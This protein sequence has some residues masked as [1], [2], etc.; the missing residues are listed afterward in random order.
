MLKT[1]CPKPVLLFAF[2]YVGNYACYSNQR[3]SFELEM[4]YFESLE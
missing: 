4:V 3:L 1:L 2:A